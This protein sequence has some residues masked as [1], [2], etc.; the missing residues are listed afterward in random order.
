MD[1]DLSEEQKMIRDS[2]VNCFS[3][4]NNNEPLVKKYDREPALDSELWSAQ[5]ELGL[6]GIMVPESQGGVGMD[7]LTLAVVAEVAGAYA[8]ATPLEYQCLAAWAIANYGSQAVVDAWLK[9]VLTGSEVA[10]LVLS[11][12]RAVDT[13]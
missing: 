12:D 5:L 8:V 1:F 6:T 13:F 11:V 4:L 3:E 9:P 2:L 10:T 7:L